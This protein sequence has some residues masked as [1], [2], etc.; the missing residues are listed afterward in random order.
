MEVIG[1]VA[2]AAQLADA[3]FHILR[4]LA[5]FVRKISTADSAAAE[6]KKRFAALQFTLNCVN[7]IVHDGGN[8]DT[9]SLLDRKEQGVRTR[10]SEDVLAC[11][12]VLTGFKAALDG[13]LDDRTNPSWLGKTRLQLQLERHD[14]KIKRLESFI[15]SRM[16]TLQI[17]LACWNVLQNTANNR[18]VTS[19]L[20]ILSTQIEQVSNTQQSRNSQRIS[21]KPSLDGQEQAH[22]SVSDSVELLLSRYDNDD[23]VE[24]LFA[25]SISEAKKVY[26]T[27][28]ESI[29]DRSATSNDDTLVPTARSSPVPS[30]RGFQTPEDEAGHQLGL[31]DA[32]VSSTCLL[33]C[34]DLTPEFDDIT[35][36]EPLQLLIDRFRTKVA[37]DLEH[38]RFQQARESLRELVVLKKELQ[39]GYDIKFEPEEYHTLQSALARVHDKLGQFEEARAIRNEL[40]RGVEMYISPIAIARNSFEHS[41]GLHFLRSASLYLDM[42]RA[43]YERST[44][45]SSS[46]RDRSRYLEAAERDAKR[47]F[48]CRREYLSIDDSLLIDAV[49]FLETIYRE[50]AKYI[51]AKVYS[52]IYLAP[53]TAIANDYASL[54]EPR[55]MQD[56]RQSPAPTATSI[57]SRASREALPIEAPRQMFRIDSPLVGLDRVSTID[58][59]NNN[60][61]KTSDTT[62]WKNDRKLALVEMRQAIKAN[63]YTTLHNLLE[64]N[65]PILITIN[66]ILFEASRMGSLEMVNYALRNR[67]NPNS[68]D[69][70]SQSALHIAVANGHLGVVYELLRAQ[71]DPNLTCTEDWTALHFAVLNRR[72]QVAQLLLGHDQH[73]DARCAQGNTP[74]HLAAKHG[75]TDLATVLVHADADPKKENKTGCTPLEVAMN[76]R[77]TD[78]VAWWLDNGLPV[79]ARKEKVARAPRH[80]LSLVKK[81]ETPPERRTSRSFLR[82]GTNS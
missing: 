29:A 69:Y 57:Y 2:A 31:V 30:T 36:C 20:K 39:D 23:L 40:F 18:H 64:H 8:W 50:Q 42:A 10:L 3:G 68:M 67:A 82:R 33:D 22:G 17:S 76:N 6:L 38:Q 4:R 77:K 5:A 43:N 14:G 74:L 28:A 46:S 55:P 34:E 53:L 32:S 44:T 19:E 48:K 11:F 66:E 45:F 35:H 1:T 37:D 49:E 71:A 16:Q 79:V 26:K 24:N 13:L 12:E 9:S 73:V 52:D 59:S 41:N 47:A 81:H 63:D 75:F 51:Y 72:P 7:A 21:H 62:R 61:R 54:I 56:R 78:F 80:I 27:T 70:E 65:R 58:S 60:G 25:Q 15:D